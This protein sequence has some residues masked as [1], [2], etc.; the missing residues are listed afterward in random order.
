MSKLCKR[1]K[2][3]RPHM[4]HVQRPCDW[5]HAATDSSSSDGPQQSVNLVDVSGPQHNQLA[6][7][8]REQ[9]DEVTRAV[10]AAMSSRAESPHPQM[11]LFLH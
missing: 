6:A 10:I 5:K 3:E 11:I 7:L 1:G 9:L 4:H 8:K 2:F